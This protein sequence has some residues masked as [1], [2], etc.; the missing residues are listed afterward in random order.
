MSLVNGTEGDWGPDLWTDPTGNNANNGAQVVSND[1]LTQS[2]VSEGPDR[3]TG[4]FQNIVGTVTKYA[5]QRDAAKNGLLQ[6]TAANGQPVYSAQPQAVATV[7]GMNMG[8]LL[9][10]G[11]AVIGG[12]LLVKAKG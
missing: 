2:T 1:V 6:G 4:F 11:A 3:W 10:I 12:L 9:I 7:G 8:G 5:V